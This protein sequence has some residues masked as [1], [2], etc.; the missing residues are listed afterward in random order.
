M[1]CLSSCL[2]VILELIM[3]QPG[4]RIVENPMCPFSNWLLRERERDGR[5]REKSKTVAALW[6]PF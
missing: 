3:C 1:G 6:L 4:D 2:K 5:E